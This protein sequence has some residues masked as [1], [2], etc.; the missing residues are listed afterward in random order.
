MKKIFA[1]FF[2]CILIFCFVNSVFA[3]SEVNNQ[4]SKTL[5]KLQYRDRLKNDG[6]LAKIQKRINDYYKVYSKDLLDLSV[7]KNPNSIE[8]KNVLKRMEESM[9]GI[10]SVTPGGLV[11]TLDLGSDPPN[12]QNNISFSLFEDGDIILVH[13][14]FC[15]Y[16]YYRHAGTYDA[17]YGKFV[18]AQAKDSGNGKGVIW[19]S[20]TWYTDN[21]D[22]AVGMAVD[23]YKSD[24]QTVI[25][26][27]MKFLRDQLGKPYSLVP[28]YNVRD[29]WY[30][31]KLPWVGWKEKSGIDISNG[32]YLIGM[33]IPDD[34]YYDADTF[35]FAYG[36]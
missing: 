16:G 29:K 19:E 4:Q 10:D 22:E 30:C 35:L 8:A 24:R 25:K 31:S 1:I 28:G 6:T 23:Y 13:D 15:I 7:L 32:D 26:E 21:Y 18:S 12:G 3:V 20:K 5:L 27:V 2:A 9:M 34:I 17:T 11:G 14:G 36:D 33:C